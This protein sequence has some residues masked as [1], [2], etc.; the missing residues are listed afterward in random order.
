MFY[1]IQGSFLG[2]P[3]VYEDKNSRL[4]GS[5]ASLMGTGVSDGFCYLLLQEQ[6]TVA[7]TTGD[8]PASKSP[9]IRQNTRMDPSHLPI[10][11]S[12]IMV[13]T[14]DLVRSPHAIFVTTFH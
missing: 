2:L 12:N 5:A 9:I 1:T 3:T 7:P 10:N 4:R 11:Q 13:R 8:D 6:W 14:Y